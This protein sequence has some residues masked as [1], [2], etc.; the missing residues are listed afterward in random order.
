MNCSESLEYEECGCYVEVVEDK[1]IHLGE[2]H[3]VV[4]KVDVEGVQLLS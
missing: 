2:D 1:D 4:L 3:Y